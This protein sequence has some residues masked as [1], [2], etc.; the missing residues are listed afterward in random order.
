MQERA[1]S[2]LQGTL[3]VTT[4]TRRRR[5]PDRGFQAQEHTVTTLLNLSLHDGNKTI[6]ALAAMNEVRLSIGACDAILPLVDLLVGREKKD[7]PTVFYKLC[8]T[9]PKRG[10]GGGDRGHGV[11]VGDRGGGGD[12]SAKKRGHGFLILGFLGLKL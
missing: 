5:S 4:L 10:L 1:N 6:I 11:T 2:H 7:A 8:T 9:V 12:S 3:R